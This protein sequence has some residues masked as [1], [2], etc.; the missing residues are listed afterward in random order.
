MW[1]IT[2]KGFISAVEYK[3]RKDH[4]EQLPEVLRPWSQAAIETA[5]EAEMIA[6]EKLVGNGFILAR[7]RVA[8]DLEQLIPY[9]P[10]LEIKEDKGADYKFRAVVPRE[11]FAACVA[12]AAWDINY[13]SHFKEVVRDRSPKE[14]AEGRYEAMLATWTALN[15]I[16][17]PAVTKT[18]SNYSGGSGSGRGNGSVV[19]SG[20]GSTST[21]T[22]DYGAKR[23]P[24][25]DDF[26]AATG[27]APVRPPFGGGDR[28][29]L[30]SQEALQLAEFEA[31]HRETA[32]HLRTTDGDT[33][34]GMVWQLMNLAYDDIDADMEVPPVP[35]ALY[36]TVF[37]YLSPGEENATVDILLNAVTEILDN[38]QG[39]WDPEERAEFGKLADKLDGKTDD[40]VKAWPKRVL[41]DV[42]KRQSQSPCDAAGRHIDSLRHSVSVCSAMSEWRGDQIRA[43]RKIARCSIQVDHE[44][45]PWD[46]EDRDKLCNACPGWYHPVA[47]DSVTETIPTAQDVQDLDAMLED[48]RVEAAAGDTPDNV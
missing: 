38:A 16:G 10:Q 8:A 47:E 19:T 21:R 36:E 22:P 9:F 41:V 3:T 43:D 35:Y 29:P 2:D 44:Q 23:Y 34:D 14:G 37:E 45:H 31:A 26:E 32:A 1:L 40:E 30:T 18:W 42:P 5:T 17:R 7:A 27:S 33:L 24:W 13:D 39:G 28:R 46:T 12:D 15:R 48:E 11:A 6:H 20:M 25:E 4:T